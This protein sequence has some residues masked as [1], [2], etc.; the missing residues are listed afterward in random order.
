M[1]TEKDLQKSRT[2]A[3][4]N[5]E[6]SVQFGLKHKNIVQLIDSYIWPNHYTI[7]KFELLD[8]SLW[9]LLFKTPEIELTP[10]EKKNVS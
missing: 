1:A 9:N 2:K 10:T 8:T 3:E 6:F 7:L 5:Q 4:L